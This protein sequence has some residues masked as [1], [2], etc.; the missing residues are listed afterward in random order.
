M[1]TTHPATRL[2]CS[3]A[4]GDTH[5]QLQSRILCVLTPRL[6]RAS[7]QEVQGISYVVIRP[8]YF[9]HSQCWHKWTDVH[10]K[11]HRLALAVH[12]WGEQKRIRSFFQSCTFR[13]LWE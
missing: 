4:I 12:A 8:T 10:S 5:S 9:Q 6:T 3:L 1:S 11:H 7:C 2:A 13:N